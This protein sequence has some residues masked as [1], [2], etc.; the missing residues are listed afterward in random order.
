MTMTEQ[1]VRDIIEDDD[2]QDYDL[3]DLPLDEM[4]RA[5]FDRSPDSDDGTQQ[6]IFSHIVAA[7]QS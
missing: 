5:I 3:A 1:D 2:D 7:L 6:Q 4:F